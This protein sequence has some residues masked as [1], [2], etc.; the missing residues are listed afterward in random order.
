M[1]LVRITVIIWQFR[2]LI[3]TG[4][5]ANDSSAVLVLLPTWI[6]TFLAGCLLPDA[7]RFLE[8][9]DMCGGSG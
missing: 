3:L 9:P 5:P 4:T 8:A 7:A 6:C 2:V 1:Y